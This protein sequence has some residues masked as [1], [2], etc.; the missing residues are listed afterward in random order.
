MPIEVK[1][2][3]TSLVV[4]VADQPAAGAPA[5]PSTP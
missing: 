4:Q 2:D 1:G 5:K 3:Q